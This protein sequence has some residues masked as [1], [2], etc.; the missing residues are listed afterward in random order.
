[1]P[2]PELPSDLLEVSRDIFAGWYGF[3]DRFGD[4]VYRPTGGTSG[5]LVV[6][7]DG[8]G[9]RWLL[10]A[11]LTP[12]L[13]L[14]ETPAD[15][16]AGLARLAAVAADPNA[17]E[18]LLRGSQDGVRALHEVEV[19]DIP[20]VRSPRLRLVRSLFWNVAQPPPGGVSTVAYQAYVCRRKLGIVLEPA[21]ADHPQ[22]QAA[23]Y[24]VATRAPWLSC[25]NV[26]GRPVWLLTGLG[27][28]YREAVTDVWGRRGD[29][30]EQTPPRLRTRWTPRVELSWSSEMP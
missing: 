17:A 13:V 14:D 16:R 26:P 3:R 6:A 27:E 9:S 5:L 19:A 18:T 21:A 25:W 12:T 22:V 8:V 23:V 15:D 7:W 1:M 29:T 2:T 4:W 10:R 11:A 24:E 28:E 30:F 20:D